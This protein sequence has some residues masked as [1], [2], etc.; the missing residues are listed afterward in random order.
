MRKL[1]LVRN[2]L[3]T[4]ERYELTPLGPDKVRM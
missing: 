2:A 1:V 4:H 3:S